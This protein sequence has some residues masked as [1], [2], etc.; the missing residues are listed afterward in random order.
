MKI[1]KNLIFIFCSCFWCHAS[2][3]TKPI[4]GDIGTNK[5]TLSRKLCDPVDN[6]ER[7]IDFIEYDMV[8]LDDLHLLLRINEKLLDLLLLKFIQLDENNG[9]N[10]ILRKHLTVFKEFL[11]EKCKI[12]YSI[13]ISN[14]KPQFGKLLFRSFSGAEIKRIFFELYEA[15]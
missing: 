11:E 12:L 10:L 4:V 1:F 3:N 14:N 13:F 5:Y 2:M 7:I 9:D 15:K 6:K 8:L